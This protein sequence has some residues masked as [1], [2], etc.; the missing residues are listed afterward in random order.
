MYFLVFL[1]KTFYK[2][3]GL[4]RSNSQA[5]SETFFTWWYRND[6]YYAIKQN[7]KPLHTIALVYAQL[8][9]LTT[10]SVKEDG[11]DTLKSYSNKI[12]V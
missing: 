4:N 11:S 7:R 9:E 10:Y 8:V 6:L 3:T 5:V 2:L 1:H 12:N